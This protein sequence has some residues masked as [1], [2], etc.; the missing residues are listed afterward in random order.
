[1]EFLTYK[2]TTRAPE[3]LVFRPV[4]PQRWLLFTGIASVGALLTFIGLEVHSQSEA[5]SWLI[6]WVAMLTIF[7]CWRLL[8]ALKADLFRLCLQDKNLLIRFRSPKETNEG[9]I[10]FKIQPDQ[11][12][13]VQLVRQRRVKGDGEVRIRHLLEIQLTAAPE[14]L[15]VQLR[16]QQDQMLAG[17]G[18]DLFTSPVWL[19]DERHLR[20]D[21]EDL[22]PDWESLERQLRATY[23]LLPAKRETVSA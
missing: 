15:V 1:M 7:L 23:M 14:P 20:V 16:Q 9:P 8:D 5:F 3:G 17:R 19:A 13:T 18:S 22:N 12:E 2:D 4:H 11:V 21:V 6:F 10:A